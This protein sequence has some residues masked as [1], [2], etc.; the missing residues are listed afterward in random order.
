MK[1]VEFANNFTKFV[2]FA[3]NFMISSWDSQTTFMKFAEAANNF[4][5]FLGLANNFWKVRKAHKN[6]MKFVNWKVSFKCQNV[7][8]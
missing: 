2:E 1:F 3:N 6:F 8:L 7:F 4:K 5:K